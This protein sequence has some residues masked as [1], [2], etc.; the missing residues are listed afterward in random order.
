MPLSRTEPEVSVSIENL[1]ECGLC[2]TE[3]ALRCP[4]ATRGR[5][6]MVWTSIAIVILMVGLAWAVQ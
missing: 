5:R 4:E 2:E 6:L 3:A 1:C